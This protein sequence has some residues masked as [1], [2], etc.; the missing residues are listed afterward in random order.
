MHSKCKFLLSA[1]VA[2]LCFSCSVSDY[3]GCS[4]IFEIYYSV[5]LEKFNELELY[6]NLNL[7]LIV[8]SPFGGSG[9]PHIINMARLHLCDIGM[10]H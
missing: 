4:L 7:V 9:S 10:F 8:L 1:S 2:C 6:L 3:V 5:I